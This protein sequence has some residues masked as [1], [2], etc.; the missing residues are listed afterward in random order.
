MPDI[1]ADRILILDFGAQYT[2]LIARR[3]RELGVYSRNLPWDADPRRDRALQAAGD[4]SVRR[5]GVGIRGQGSGSSAASFRLGR[6]GARV[7]ATACRPWPLQLGGE[8]QSATHREFGAA[9]VRPT[10]PSRLFDGLED[11]R[12]PAGRRVLDVWMSHGDR[13]VDVAARIPGD[14]CDRQRAAC[15]HG[16]RGRRFYGA[17]IPSGGDPYLAGRRDLAPLRARDRRLRGAP[18]RQATSSRTRGAHPRSGR[19]GQGA[20]GAVRWRRLVG[21][22]GAAASGHRRAAHVRIRRSRP[23]AARRGGPG[24]GDLR[25]AHGRA[26]HPRQRRTALSR[27]AARRGRS[28]GKAQGHRAR[29]HRG[30]R[31]GSGEARGCEMAGAGHHLSGRHRV[32][33]REDRQGARHQVAP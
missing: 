12:D 8:V 24:D 22:G 28:R 16:G 19:F 33:R 21:A 1:H 11:N 3:V 18:G 20:S 9:Q 30:V 5:P 4:H 29:V 31:R 25:R 13:V 6:A 10:G 26:R 27:R 32:G 2:Q 14:R 17:A 15:G 23:V 7:S